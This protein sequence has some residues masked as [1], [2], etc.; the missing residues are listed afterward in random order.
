MKNKIL[1][2]ILISLLTLLA[3]LPLK[4]LYILSDIGTVIIYY[5][6]R[7]RRK[8]VRHNL[9]L[10][11]PDKSIHEIKKIE[12]KFYRHFCDCIIE[13]VKLLHISDKEIDR[14]VKLSN[15]SLIEQIAE[16]NRPI[17]LFLGHYC[18]WEWVQAISRQYKYPKIN[19]EIYRPVHDPVMDKIMLK[20]RSKFGHIL[21]PQKKAVRTIL[22]LK[23]TNESFMIGFISDQRPNSS[24]L[25]HWTTFLNQETAYSAGGEE[26][27]KKINAEYVY[28]DIEKVK[29]GY[30]K[31]TF[32]IVTPQEGDEKYPYTLQFMQMME[33]T[34]LR[35]PEYWL[36]SHKRWRFS[37]QDILNKQQQ[38]K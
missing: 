10:V 32:K 24:N 5:I 34:I 18:N 19:G 37:K 1:Y 17:V 20:I 35:A 12:F 33:T 15:G 28:L 25:N 2:N 21:I 23:N 7:Y 36:W 14:R 16:S 38:I 6:V 31:M 9:L 3:C 8:T 29:R 22:A 27:G 26:I 4:V 30:Y 11:F 13:T